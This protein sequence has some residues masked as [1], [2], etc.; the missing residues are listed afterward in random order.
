MKSPASYRV[1]ACHCSCLAN[2]VHSIRAP[3][4]E[5]QWL[6]GCRW[7]DDSKGSLTGG[8]VVAVGQLLLQLAGYYTGVHLLSTVGCQSTPGGRWVVVPD[9]SPPA[10]GELRLPQVLPVLQFQLRRGS[11]VGGKPPC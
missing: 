5:V 8:A 1:E 6:K 4:T 3:P 9:W 2:T 11:S 7:G 10:S